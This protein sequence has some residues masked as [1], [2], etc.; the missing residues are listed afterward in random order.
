MK[1]MHRQSLGIALLL[2]G[3]LVGLPTPAAIAGMQ[4]EDQADS[5]AAARQLRE[6]FS[7]QAQYRNALR[8][9]HAAYGEAMKQCKGMSGSDKTSC[10]NDAKKHLQND[11]AYARQ[12]YIRDRQLTEN[13]SPEASF[14]RSR[15][16]AYAAYN[17]AVKGCKDLSGKDRG[18]CVKDAKSNLRDDLAYARNQF[19]EEASTS[20]GSSAS[21]GRGKSGGSSASHT[22]R[23][24]QR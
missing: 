24:N 18:A 23:G 3:S 9:A 20:T 12:S 5:S 4:R 21:R 16:E 19:G 11:L 17:E 10:I 15:R 1:S 8:E 14:N 7:P 13:R 2:I 6:D 22:G